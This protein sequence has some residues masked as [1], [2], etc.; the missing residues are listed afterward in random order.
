MVAA[1]AACS[2]TNFFV[3]I[4][5]SPIR[6]LFQTSFLCSSPSSVHR[7]IELP[8]FIKLNIDEIRF[9]LERLIIFEMSSLL[10]TVLFSFDLMFMGFC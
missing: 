7:F 3:D 6:S 9:V 8:L 4:D 2:S 1:N 10:L 5:L